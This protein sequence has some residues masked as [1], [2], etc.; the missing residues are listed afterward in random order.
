MTYIGGEGTGYEAVN[1]PLSIG[2]ASTAG[3]ITTAHL[4]DTQ[5]KPAMSYNDKKAQWWEKMTQYKSTIY[6]VPKKKFGY[7][8]A[9]FYNAGGKNA[10]KPKG[11]RIGIALSND[12]KRWHRYK[13]NPVFAH[14]TD[15]TITGDAQI[16]K[17]G[18]L[19]VMFYFSAF[20]PTREYSAYNTFA[21]SYDM[22][23]WTD[24][25]GEDLIIPSKPYDD[26]FA[27]KSYVVKWDNVVYHFYCAVN[28]AGQRGIAVATSKPMGKSEVSFPTPD[29]V[30]KRFTKSLN[31]DWLVNFGGNKMLI[32]VPFNL[33]DYY[34]ALQKVHGNLHGKATCTKTFMAPD[35]AGKQYFL[36]LE[37]VGT[38]ADISLNGKSEAAMT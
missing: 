5:S 20:N 18:N 37:G 29:P 7:Q 24:W 8:F 28:K 11:E 26:M 21:A 16:V 36:R 38:Y 3:D 6:R 34:G 1:A 10:T 13:G 32:D 30:G 4:W 22:V 35:M 14:D 31:S 27:H 15:G 2:L 19:Y 33:D 23:N 9:M 25:Q 17:M 12:M